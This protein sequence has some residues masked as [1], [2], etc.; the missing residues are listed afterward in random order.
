VGI[1]AGLAAVGL[2]HLNDILS[3]M[4]QTML[5]YGEKLGLTGKAFQER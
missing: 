3:Y 5:A 2:E 4:E 1:S